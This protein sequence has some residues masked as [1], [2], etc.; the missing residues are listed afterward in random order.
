MLFT[1]ME[2]Q[3]SENVLET[4]ELLKPLDR[5]TQAILIARSM[6]RAF[7][8]CV[9]TGLHNSELFVLET[10]LFL[11]VSCHA[12]G[13]EVSTAG[14][15]PW[16]MDRASLTF[17]TPAHNA[18]A[19]LFDMSGPGRT[20]IDLETVLV[21]HANTTEIAFQFD[22]DDARF[23]NEIATDLRHLKAGCS[24]TDVFHKPLWNDPRE[25][26]ASTKVWLY[27]WETFWAREANKWVFWRDWYQ[28]LLDGEPLDWEL[29]RRIAII[30]DAIW[31]AGPEAVS[32]E[33]D[34]VRAKLDL[35]NGIAE[36]EA[37]LRR[38]KVNRFG[39]GGNSPPESFDDLP[40]AEELVIVSKPLK[41]LKDE[42]EKTNPDPAILQRTFE[43]LVVALNKG[44]GWCLRKGDLIVDTGI[45]WAIP[46]AGTGYLALKPEKL[47]AVI[48]ALKKLLAL[49]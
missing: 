12:A 22:E 2:F 30:D 19:Y 39:I 41:D 16:P 43:A 21:S 33:I 17:A 47:E 4:V 27:Q 29:Q 44:V 42:V 46:A 14:L 40:I 25:A 35:E 34:F 5:S 15:H 8:G 23:C 6:L 9:P 1:D 36:L 10:R 32:L 7:R 45:K 11:A 13:E 18:F 31:A 26:E 20:K 48:E 38:V 3:T 24:R 28:G 49:L 37:D